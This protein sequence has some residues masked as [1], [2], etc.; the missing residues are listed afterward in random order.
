[1]INGGQLVVDALESFGTERV[2]CVP[3]ESFLPVL[4]ALYDSSIEITI[5]RQEGGASMMAEA[6]GKLTRKPGICIVTRAPGATNASAGVHI[7]SQD[8]TPMILLVGQIATDTT[9]REMFQ[10]LNYE[11]FFG[12]MVK[13]VAEISHTHRIPEMMS[14]AWHV[15]TSGRPG[16]VVLSLPEDVL[17][18]LVEAPAKPLI[19]N[20]IVSWPSEKQVIDCVDLLQSAERPLA[21]MGGSLWTEESARQFTSFAETLGL[22]VACSFR[23]Q[24]LFNHKHPNYIGDVGLGINPELASLIRNTDCLMLVGAR[25]SEIPSQNFALLDVPI[26]QCK[27][28]HIYPDSSEIGKLYVPTLGIEAGPAEFTALLKNVA[29]SNKKPNNEHVR[30]A[31]LSYKKWSSLDAAVPEAKTMKAVMHGL[32]NVL[33]DDAV[34]CNGAGNYASWLHRFYPYQ[35][36]NSQLAPTSGSMGYG[37]P[38]S[39]AAKLEY[40]DKKVVAVAGD[41][42]LQMTIQELA[43]AA[44]YNLAIVVLV[45]DNGMYGTIRMHQ[46]RIYPKRVA[47]TSI[48]NPDF[49]ALAKSYGIAGYTA[50]YRNFAGVFSDALNSNELALIHV[51]VERAVLS[52]TLVI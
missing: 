37:L 50:D 20:Q 30:S 21:I 19:T 51:N 23:R 41:G 1:M 49:A 31:N 46:E 2:F 13:W 34:I 38:A 12:N 32:I 48:S 43:T 16:P 28:I 6:T 18:D 22:P 52:P 9:Y 8:S 5:C 27:L 42:C 35:S 25:F 33:P 3:G 14:R 24:M 44:Q 10:E 26:P 45:I 40:P 29:P 7:A 39:I 47:G 15:A 11:S 17:S 36:F 4:N